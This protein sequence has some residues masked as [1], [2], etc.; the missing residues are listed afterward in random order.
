MGRSTRAKPPK[1][2]KLTEKEVEKIKRD[3]TQIAVE[4]SSVIAMAVMVENHKLTADQ[5]CEDMRDYARWS[6]YIGLH[7]LQIRDV[8]DIIHEQTELEYEHAERLIRRFEEQWQ[9]HQK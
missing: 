5:I 7:L 4:I 9:G 3:A 6:Q 1:V 2:V 8:L